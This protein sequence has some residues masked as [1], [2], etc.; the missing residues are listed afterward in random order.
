MNLAASVFGRDEEEE[1]VMELRQ[2]D[3]DEGLL[4]VLTA[5]DGRFPMSLKAIA[6][7]VVLNLSVR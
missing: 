1:A 2:A 4:Y 5:L 6:S 3:V 7:E